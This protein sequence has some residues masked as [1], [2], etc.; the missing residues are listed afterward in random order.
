MILKDLTVA[1]GKGALELLEV[2]PAGKRPMSFADFLRG[3][4]MQAGDRL[5]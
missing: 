1:T 2:Q 3:N 5:V 4:T